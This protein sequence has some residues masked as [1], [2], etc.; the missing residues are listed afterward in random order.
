M[1]DGGGEEHTPI[2]AR[3]IH[4][5]RKVGEVVDVLAKRLDIVDPLALEVRSTDNKDPILDILLITTVLC[6][7]LRESSTRYMLVTAN[8]Q[9]LIRHRVPDTGPV[10]GDVVLYFDPIRIHL[11]V[12]SVILEEN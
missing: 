9:K 6:A 11:G 8:R 12:R 4:L 3:V 5:F 2:E 10:S 1:E 7:T